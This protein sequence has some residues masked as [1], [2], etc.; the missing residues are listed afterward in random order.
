MTP[1]ELAVEW[2]DIEQKLM[3]G[4]II[5]SH[6]R[7]GLFSKLIQKKTGS[8]WSH[9]ALIFEDNRV[10]KFGSPLIIEGY[11]HGIEIHRLK[12]YSDRLELFDIGVKR[13]PGLSKEERLKFVKSF[14]WNNI[15]A[16]YDHRR[17]WTYMLTGSAETKGKLTQKLRYRSINQ[18]AFICSTFV[19]KAFHHFKKHR[20][21]AGEFTDKMHR[22]LAL[23]EEVS[24]GTIAQDENFDWIFNKHP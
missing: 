13:F 5:L 14:M 3:V 7:K 4:D 15:D 1:E 18:E 11:S 10:I 23:E 12:K 21:I 8:Y 24:P 22:E 20:K 17:I 2:P 19:H 16:P 6:A 9:A